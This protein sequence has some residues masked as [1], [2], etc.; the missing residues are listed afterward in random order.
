MVNALAERGEPSLRLEPVEDGFSIVVSAPIVSV[1]RS[2]R[3]FSPAPVASEGRASEPNR[4]GPRMARQAAV[5][6]SSGRPGDGF[7]FSSSPRRRSRCRGSTASTQRVAGIGFHRCRAGVI[8]EDSAATH[9]VIEARA[10]D[11]TALLHRITSASLPPT[12]G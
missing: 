8:V 6:R 2:S 7:G 1:S 5:R 4:T 11:E 10:H 3:E 12:A 9:T